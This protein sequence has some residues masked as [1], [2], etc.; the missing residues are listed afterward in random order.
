MRE[1]FIPSWAHSFTQQP[2]SGAS[3]YVKRHIKPIVTLLILYHLILCK[4]L[5]LLN[6]PDAQGHDS[7]TNLN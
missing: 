7:F 6:F 1:E 2:I 5:I 4:E 3:T